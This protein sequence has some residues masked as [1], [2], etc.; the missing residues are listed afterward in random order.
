MNTL[1]L[2]VFVCSMLWCCCWTAFLVIE[3]ADIL[4]TLGYLPG[5]AGF[6]AAAALGAI[7]VAMDIES[8]VSL[9]EKSQPAADLKAPDTSDSL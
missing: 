6:T 1:A 2:V 5:I 8:W 4:L 9:M 3:G 7:S